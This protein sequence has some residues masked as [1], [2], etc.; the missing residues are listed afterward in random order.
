[1]AALL[2]SSAIAVVVIALGFIGVL[3]FFEKQKNKY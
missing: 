1:M 2:F 3:A